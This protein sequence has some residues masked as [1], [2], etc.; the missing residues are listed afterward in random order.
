MSWVIILYI[1]VMQAA[2]L[3]IHK[4]ELLHK[5]IVSDMGGAVSSH[6]RRL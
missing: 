2:V 6:C 5:G 3:E 4:S 1:C